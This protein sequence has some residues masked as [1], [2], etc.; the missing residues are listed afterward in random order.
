M[1][2]DTP[3]YDI[4]F[5]VGQDEPSNADSK[6]SGVLPLRLAL[7]MSRNIPAVKMYLA[8]GGEDVAKPYLQ[9]LG[10]SG[11][12][13]S[14]HYGYPL[15]LGAGETTMLELA[16]AYSHLTTETPGELNPILEIKANDGSLLYQ[17]EVQEKEE[18]IPA[19]IKYLMWK[20]LSEPNNRLAGWVTKFNVS[21]LTY[22][23]KTGTSNVKTDRGNR[24]R[25]GWMAAYMPD[26]LVLMR[27]GNAN[28]SPMQANA[29]GG[30]IQADPIKN[31]LKSLLDNNYLSNR[32]MTNVETST[33][34]ISKVTG[35]IPA[36]NTPADL[37]T[38]TMAYINSV[39]GTVDTPV[40]EIEYDALCL[41]LSSPLTP[42]AEI[43]KGYVT[44]VTS[45]MP[46]GNDLE[47]IKAYLLASSQLSM[48]GFETTT[49]APF[50]ILLESPKE[51]CEFREPAISDATQ[52]QI[53]DPQ[54]DQR[55]S[56][57]PEVMYSVKS[58]GNL[59]SLSILLDDTVVYTKTYVF[60]ATEDLGTATLDLT[61][62][63]P[64]KHTLT[65]QAINTKGSMNRTSYTTTLVSS[66]KEA[67]YLVKEQSSKKTDGSY[68]LVFDDELSAILGG[69]I[70]VEGEVI[71]SF[72]GRLASFSTAA[73][74]VEISVKDAYDNVLSQT[75]D[76]SEL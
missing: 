38:S 9:S 47:D 73:E 25:D 21:G 30:T 51:Y 4:P 54:D 61:S 74:S 44:Q 5:K 26:R 64:G 18:I 32:E 22:A 46:G 43:K 35:K 13:D 58:D 60:N 24:P 3:I 56:P 19:G 10:M 31:F 39:P 75:L 71:H 8:V 11:I 2:I 42:P 57:K 48:T 50:N 27:A 16:S 67:P 45:F 1:T 23:L 53:I 68:V 37:V 7:G 28:A 70:S 33:L 40:L 62:F 34:S 69:S 59:K 63:T 55:I 17:K 6:F 41:G 29:F 76:L 72:E 12:L 66:D 36:D 52:I 65:V 20:I 15:A 49:P 14:I